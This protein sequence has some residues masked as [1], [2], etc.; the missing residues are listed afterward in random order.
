MK[1]KYSKADVLQKAKSILLVMLGTVILA[2]GTSVF[3]LPFDLVTGGVSGYSIVIKTLLPFEFI[4]KEMI[5]AV[6]TWS[7][8]VLGFII[9]GRSF[10]MKSLISTIVYPIATAAFS[11]LRSPEFMNGFFRLED[12]VHSGIAI[13]LAAIF[14]GVFVGLGC[15]L[16]F[17]GGG[18]TGG[19]DVIA[20]TL[21]KIFKKA[22]SSVTI[23]IVDASAVVLGMF[24]IGDFIVSLLGIVSAFIAAMV[25]DKV[26]V[27]G[28]KA[29]VAHI[30]TDKSE[31][32]NEQI[33]ERLDRTTTLFNVTGGYSGERK[34]VVMV[35]FTMAQYA[36]LM[37]IVTKL[38]KNAFMTINRAHEINGEGWTK[39]ELKRKK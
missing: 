31:E 28:D 25:I 1:F 7:L 14:S 34:T 37:A 32:L 4:T 35:S 19:V 21:C 16:S 3:L 5:I 29:F 6:L 24:I 17:L 11:G 12:S 23:F 33:R 22:K 38:D 20:F 18:S 2:F 39:Y 15:A 9:L 10:A 27:G 36:E 13:L 8:F 26:F 30:V